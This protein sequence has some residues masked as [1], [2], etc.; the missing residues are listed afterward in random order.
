[1]AKT[2]E[3]NRQEELVMLGAGEELRAN[4]TISCER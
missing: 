2:G 1:M 4:L 3:L